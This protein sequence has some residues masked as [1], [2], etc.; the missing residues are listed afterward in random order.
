MYPR[1]CGAIFFHVPLYTPRCNASSWEGSQLSVR[2]TRRP[3]SI[4]LRGRPRLPWCL[5]CRCLPPTAAAICCRLLAPPLC[6]VS[7]TCLCCRCVFIRCLCRRLCC[8]RLSRWGHLPLCNLRVWRQWRQACIRLS[9]LLSN[10]LRL[11]SMDG[12]AIAQGLEAGAAVGRQPAPRKGA[13]LASLASSAGHAAGRCIRAAL[14][15][16]V[17]MVRCIG[18][19]APPETRWLP[20]T[21]NKAQEPLPTLPHS[22]SSSSDGGQARRCRSQNASLSVTS[23][24]AG[25]RRVRNRC[26]NNRSA[27]WPADAALCNAGTRGQASGATGADGQSHARTAVAVHTHTRAASCGCATGSQRPTTH[28]RPVAAVQLDHKLPPLWPA[29]P[30]SAP[31]RWC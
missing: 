14:S 26:A 12:S 9:Q 18:A 13:M 28:G 25:R 24:C 8:I 4:C 29:G 17:P 10:G 27:G 2:H 6:G 31:C 23:T 11:C 7:P 20:Q 21:T 15:S 1:C 3:R 30:S 5:C 22:R 19:S 16:Q